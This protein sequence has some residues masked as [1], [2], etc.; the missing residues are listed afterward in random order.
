MQHEAISCHLIDNYLGDE[1][2]I[3]LPSVS[4]QATVSPQPPFLQTKELQ[5]PLK[6]PPLDPSPASSQVVAFGNKTHAQTIAT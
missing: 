1:T 4:F 6:I 2:H 5:L 3:H